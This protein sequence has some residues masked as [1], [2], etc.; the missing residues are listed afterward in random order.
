MIEPVAREASEPVA[1]DRSG[2]TRYFREMGRFPLL[3]PAQEI[4]VGRRIEHERRA[5]LGRVLVV[6]VVRRRLMTLADQVGRDEAAPDALVD[7]PDDGVDGARTVRRVLRAVRR[8]RM[9]GGAPARAAVAALPLRSSLVADLVRNVHGVQAAIAAATREERYSEVSRLER[10]TGVSLRRLETIVA[11]VERAEVDLRKAKQ[12][13][14]QANLRLV[15]SIAKRYLRSGVPLEDLIQDGNIG[16]LRAVDKF[17]YRRGFRFSTYAT[18]WIRQAIGRALADRGRTIRI[19]AH[20]VEVLHKISRCRAEAMAELQREPE[21][22][23]LARRVQMPAATMQ[24]LL[25]VTRQPLSLDAPL[26]DDDETT[27][28][29]FIE[30]RAAT[31]PVDRVLAADTSAAVRRMLERLTSRE[32]DV[33]CSRFGLEDDRPQTLDEIGARYSLTRERI[34]QIEARA[35]A[36]LRERRFGWRAPT[37][38]G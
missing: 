33:L 25:D 16:L 17:D 11:A 36:K 9:G 8:L 23:D 10:E 22:H 18:W 26:R 31:S 14:A 38:N 13:L 2:V 12:A 27:L 28:R 35:I 37:T 6:P 32:R 29:D 15:V 5:L 21:P 4:E 30:D 20:M 1:V 3:T 34:R 19:P 7:L 24:G